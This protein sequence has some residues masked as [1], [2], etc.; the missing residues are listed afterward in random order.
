MSVNLFR[1]LAACA[2]FAVFAGCS[3]GEQE[4]AGKT[5]TSLDEVKKESAEALDAAGRYTLEKKEEYAL[6][7]EQRL[8]ELDERTKTLQEKAKEKSGAARERI[9]K[10]LAELQDEKAAAREKLKE[11]RSKSEAAWKDMRAGMEAA[12]EELEKAYK[13]AAS[14]FE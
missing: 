9:E 3:S 2:A 7:I 4:P 1:C 6:A 11:L 10:Q 8:K 14:H 13:Q 5:K 12:M